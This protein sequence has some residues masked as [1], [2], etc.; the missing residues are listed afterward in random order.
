M[1]LY[2]KDLLNIGHTVYYKKGYTRFNI[3]AKTCNIEEIFLREILELFSCKIIST[4]D[5]I[6]TDDKGKEIFDVAIQTNLPW[7]VY[8]ELSK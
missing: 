3:D 7:D 1:K 6:W 8:L 4:E 2:K 5:Y